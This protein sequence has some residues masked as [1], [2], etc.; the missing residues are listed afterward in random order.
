MYYYYSVSGTGI[1]GKRKSERDD[2]DDDDDDGGESPYMSH[3]LVQLE[4]LELY[5]RLPLATY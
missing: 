1:L 5:H 2:D 4:F 3:I